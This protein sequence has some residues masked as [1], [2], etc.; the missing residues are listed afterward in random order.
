MLHYMKKEHRQKVKQNKP[1]NLPSYLETTVIK[2]VMCI[3]LKPFFMH[4]ICI[5]NQNV[6][7]ANMQFFVNYLFSLY[8]F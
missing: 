8:I 1:Q 4:V 2:V 7:K 5:V 3:I 6:Y